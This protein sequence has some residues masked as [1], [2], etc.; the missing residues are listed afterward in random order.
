MAKWVASVTWEDIPHINDEVKKALYNSFPDHEKEARSKG[1]PS[2]GS[3][4]I[5]PI[6]ESDFVIS[7]FKI[8]PY[9]PKCYALDV[10]FRRTA[11][12]WGAIDP[13]SGIVYLYDE[14][15]C[16]QALPEVHAAAIKRRG[17]WIPGV[18]DPAA[19][20]SS[21]RDGR[22]LLDEYKQLGLDLQLADNSIEAGI[23]KMLGRLSNG[24][25][26]LFRNCQNFLSEYRIYRY[27]DKGEPAREQQDHLMD[28]TRYLLMSGLRRAIVRPDD[29]DEL[30]K[31]RYSMKNFS[32]DDITGY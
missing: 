20:K 2:V 29:D 24:Q 23:L 1:I 27:N 7:P 4:K 6:L 14:Y 21:E 22:K 31:I 8:P 15:Y 12:I 32:R 5:Y 10:G 16:G 26:K 19:R 28:A 3:G 11:C 30:G 25:L 9:W 18:I 17:N 13:D